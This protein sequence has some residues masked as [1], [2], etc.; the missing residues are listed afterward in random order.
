MRVAGR[1]AEVIFA[2]GLA[3][4]PEAKYLGAFIESQAYTAKYRALI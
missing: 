1:I 4:A 3:R 2:R